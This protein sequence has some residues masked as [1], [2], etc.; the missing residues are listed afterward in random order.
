MDKFRREFGLYPRGSAVP[1]GPEHFEA[2]PETWHVRMI[3]AE[4]AEDHPPRV[5]KLPWVLEKILTNKEQPKF[6]GR[7]PDWK[8][9]VRAWD[10]YVATLRQVVGAPL[11]EDVMLDI[12]VESLDQASQN[13]LEAAREAKP[14]LTYTEFW[15]TMVREF[16]RD[17]SADY[18]DE[19]NRVTLR[20][21]PKL[22]VLEWRKF[23]AAFGK[24]LGRVTDV[25]DWEIEKKIESELPSELRRNLKFEMARRQEGTFWVKFSSP[26]PT[27]PS[28]VEAMLSG[29]MGRPN[30]V[31]ESVPGGDSLDCQTAQGRDF[32]L[33]LDGW[34]INDGNLRISTYVKRMTASEIFRW[35]ATQLK[36][37]ESEEE[38]Y[39]RPVRQVSDERAPPLQIFLWLG[40]PLLLLSKVAS[41]LRLTK[42]LRV[43]G[44]GE[45]LRARKKKILTP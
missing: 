16:D 21:V 32:I 36:V 23:Q 13:R 35:V 3:N 24:A 12:L 31:L 5:Q 20:G 22:N 38:Y 17:M 6:S 44:S 34:V 26:L 42:S 7:D 11:G 15:R 18:R 40:P 28:E 9:F 27:S 41:P 25:T 39:P 33:A 10:R 8:D 4:F 30:V 19:W 37:L 1:F 45:I 29:A 2:E 43:V 14:S